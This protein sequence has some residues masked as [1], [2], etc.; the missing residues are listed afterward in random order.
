M[1]FI[2]P[3][4]RGFFKVYSSLIHY[5][6]MTLP[7]STAPSPAPPDPSSLQKRAGL[8]GTANQH[9][10]RA[11]DLALRQ[12]IRLRHKRDILWHHTKQNKTKANL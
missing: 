6:S 8:L 9:S 12:S 1:S 4:I 11:G 5:T 7:P 2:K 10:I 3:K